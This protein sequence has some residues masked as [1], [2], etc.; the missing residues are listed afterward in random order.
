MPDTTTTLTTEQRVARLEELLA[1]LA[2]DVGGAS[3]NHQASRREG[4]AGLIKETRPAR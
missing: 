2:L 3:M 4:I 1:Q